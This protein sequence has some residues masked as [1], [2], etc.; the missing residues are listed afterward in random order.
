[1]TNDEMIAMAL[2]SDYLSE[3][4]VFESLPN[5]RIRHGFDRKMRKMIKSYYKDEQKIKCI[6]ELNCA[7]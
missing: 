1:M 3:L 2:K 4:S 5:I 6:K 7:Y